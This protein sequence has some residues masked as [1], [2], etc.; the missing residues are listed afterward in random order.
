M[1]DAVDVGLLDVGA[2]PEVV[3]VDQ[4]ERRGCPGVH[5]LAARTRAHVH[6][7]VDRRVDLGIGQAHVRLGAAGRRRPPRW[8][9]VACTWL[10]RTAT[11]SALARARA[12]V[13][14]CASTCFLRA[15]SLACAA[16][17][18]RARLVEVLRGRDLLAR[19]GPGCARRSSCAA[20]RSAAAACTWASVAASIA[21]ACAVWW[22]GLALLEPQRGLGLA[23]LRRQA[24]GVLRVV[25]GVGLQLVG[26]SACARSWPFLTVSPSSTQELGD[27]A[28]HLGADEDVV[29]GDDPRER[30][31]R[32]AQGRV[33]V[34]AAGTRPRATRR[35]TSAGA[36]MILKQMYKTSV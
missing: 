22:L 30:D 4:R 24:G 16:F 36:F 5:V 12:T 14:R 10:R 26:V 6:E 25:G 23:H 21:S 19:P 34:G 31:G 3:G 18:G 13:A 2:H 15:S 29:G 32:R 1:R 17:G 7:A 35:R 11:C 28:G 8:C 33:G 9:C 20:S 27:L